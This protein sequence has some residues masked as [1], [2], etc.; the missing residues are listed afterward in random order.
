MEF[1]ELT[2]ETVSSAVDYVCARLIAVGIEGMS[3]EDAEDFSAFVEENSAYWDSVDEALAAK[4][5]DGTR[6]KIYLP[7]NAQGRDM[8]AAVRSAMEALRADMPETDLGAL[9]LQ[10]AG[11]D[12]ADWETAWQKYYKPTE[13]G[14]RLLIVPEWEPIPPT[15]RVVFINNPGLA[16]G[17]GTHASTHLCL[18]FLEALITGGET[19]LDV[20]CGSGIL[21][22]TALKLGAA[23]ADAVDIDM[24][25]AEAAARNAVRNQIGT[26]RYSTH[27]GDILADSGLLARI[28]GPYDLVLM[29][30]IPDVIIPAHTQVPPLLAPGGRYIISGI[31]DGRKDEVLSALEATGFTLS[32]LREK[33]GWIAACLS[34]R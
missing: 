15:D 13:I 17:T 30:I 22:I 24:H 14:N 26:D 25:A 3:I 23:R 9:S 29:N 1:T 4:F 2:I 27:A 5:R 7:A 12:S 19:L 33:D 6:V 20:G 10:A 32:A 11:V 18:E 16:F 8:A 34:C 21:S 31:I 28:G